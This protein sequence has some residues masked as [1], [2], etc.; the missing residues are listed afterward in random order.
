MED[1]IDLMTCHHRVDGGGAP[2]RRRQRLPFY[3]KSSVVVP[4]WLLQ[5]NCGPCRYCVGLDGYPEP[6]FCVLTPTEI[7]CYIR[8][9]FFPSIAEDCKVET[10]T[11]SSS[12][13]TSTTEHETS[14]VQW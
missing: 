6:Y 9:E 5:E 4:K 3:G 8:I 2:H 13:P 11:E 10:T 12:T 7:P 14:V 1:S